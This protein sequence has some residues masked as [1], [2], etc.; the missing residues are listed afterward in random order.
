METIAEHGEIIKALKR[1]NGDV[2]EKAIRK[3]IRNAYEGVLR[4]VRQYLKQ[5]GR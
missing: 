4:N 2:T 1:R 3:H 5:A